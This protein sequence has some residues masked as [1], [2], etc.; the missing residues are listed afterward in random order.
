[1]WLAITTI[2]GLFPGWFELQRYYPD[3]GTE[4]ALLKLGGQT[5]SM[6][7]G[8]ALGGSLKLRSYPS[9]LGLSISRLFG[10]FQKPLK[11]PW[12]EIE[13]KPSSSLFF[14]MTKLRLGQAAN[15]TLKI[16]ARS[17]AKL[18][19]AVPQTDSRRVR[20]PTAARVSRRSMAQAMLVQWLATSGLAAAFFYFAPR[21]S[22]SEDALPLGVCI[23]FPA[24][25]FGMGQLIRYARES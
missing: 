2:C 21:L 22:G 8:V 19:D 16:S 14:P 11:I 1:M 20:M 9:G 13:A 25:F 10:P 7:A 6:G 18:I 5:G 17:W 23:G 12:S 4:K 3:D 24:A 15:G